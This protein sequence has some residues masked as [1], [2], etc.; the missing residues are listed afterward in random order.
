[1]GGRKNFEFKQKNCKLN[2]ITSSER[3]RKGWTNQRECI[4]NFDVKKRQFKVSIE[5]WQEIGR[6]ATEGWIQLTLW[7]WVIF[8]DSMREKA[9][10][11][12]NMFM[13][14]GGG[15][16]I[17]SLEEGD[18]YKIPKAIQMDIH[19]IKNIVYKSNAY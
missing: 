19:N 4:R 11:I 7:F 12:Q 1:M 10:D 15:K 14:Q 18:N 2:D 6:N 3:V 17:H 13:K 5:K 9:F 8:E 16:Y